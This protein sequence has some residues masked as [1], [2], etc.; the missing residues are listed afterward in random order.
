MS[1]DS[2]VDESVFTGDESEVLSEIMRPGN[3]VRLPPGYPR[4]WLR[5]MRHDLQS[6]LSIVAVLL[7]LSC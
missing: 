2:V 7:F 6:A 3:S 5:C 1:T 4:A